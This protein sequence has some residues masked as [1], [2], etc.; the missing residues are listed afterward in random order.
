MVID[1]CLNA[2]PFNP[3]SVIGW[4]VIKYTP[5]DLVGVFRTE[6][7]AREVAENLNTDYEVV[8]GTHEVGTD[9]FI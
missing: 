2:D 3:E 5:W 8:F 4:G 1:D 9:S 6:R 7:K